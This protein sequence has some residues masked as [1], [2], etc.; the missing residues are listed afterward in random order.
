[1]ALRGQEPGTVV[2][3]CGSKRGH[4]GGGLGSYGRE[5]ST[6]K[7]LHFHVVNFVEC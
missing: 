5:V 6:V 1:M 4:V 2:A 3:G 7:I